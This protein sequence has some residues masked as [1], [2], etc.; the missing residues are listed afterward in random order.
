MKRNFLLPLL[1]SLIIFSCG[2]DEIDVSLDTSGTTVLNFKN[3]ETPIANA[4][5][6]V[7]DNSGSSF[8]IGNSFEGLTDENG[9]VRIGPLNT[10]TYFFRL[11]LGDLGFLIESFEIISGSSTQK[12]FDITQFTSNAE[13]EIL[14][15]NDN[16]NF[17]TFSYYMVPTFL[18]VTGENNDQIIANS[19]AGSVLGGNIVFSNIVT[20]NYYLYVLADGELI[21][22][23][24]FNSYFVQR[25]FDFSSSV[26]IPGSLT[27]I[28]E[29]WNISN[30]VELFGGVTVSNV[31][32][33]VSFDSEECTFTFTDNS[34]YVN[35]Y[36]ISTFS[37]GAI[38]IGL[39]DGFVGRDDVNSI[40]DME[41]T[42]EGVLQVDYRDDTFESYRATFN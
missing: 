26:T 31:I 15:E 33:S 11:N 27:L 36:F 29:N 2:R 8:Q 32:R 40:F 20:G 17:G 22:F 37:N 9:N 18:Q 12:S 24:S 10:G 38:G 21:R 3:G 39:L 19:T 5:I 6:R 42:T 28:A 16:F 30:T 25:D 41:Y 14:N 13:F 35:E 34:T 7:S 1:L 23:G 4:E